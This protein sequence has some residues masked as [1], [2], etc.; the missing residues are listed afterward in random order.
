MIIHRRSHATVGKFSE[1]VL[2]KR[3]HTNIIILLLFCQV[4]W[5]PGAPGKVFYAK[6]VFDISPVL[7]KLRTK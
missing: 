5:I 2:K 6:Q 4:G 1:K 3:E 7:Q